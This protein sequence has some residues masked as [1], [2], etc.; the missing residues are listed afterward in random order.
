MT[1]PPRLRFMQAIAD[2]KAAGLD[3]LAF[4]WMEL[5]HKLH[6]EESL[7]DQYNKA[8]LERFDA[9]RSL[10]EIEPEAR[11]VK[12]AVTKRGIVDCQVCVPADFTDEQVKDFANFANPSGLTHGWAIRKQGSE[13]LAGDNERVPCDARAGCVHIMLDC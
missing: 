2:A 4:F 1:T 9:Q 10:R 6:P 11:Q 12:P 8:T 13:W 5:H 3:G 7:L